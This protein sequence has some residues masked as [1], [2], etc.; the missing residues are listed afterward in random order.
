VSSAEDLVLGD[1]VFDDRVL[2]M[3]DVYLIYIYIYVFCFLI[4]A[5]LHIRNHYRQL[6][7]AAA[8]PLRGLY[9]QTNI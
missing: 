8:M 6:Q 4:F 9:T 7:M 1:C 2:M 3:F 5:R